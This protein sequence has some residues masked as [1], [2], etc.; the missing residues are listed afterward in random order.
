[1]TGQ[2]ALVAHRRRPRGTRKILAA[3][4]VATCWTRTEAYRLPY[5]RRGRVTSLWQSVHRQGRYH[6]RRDQQKPQN[7]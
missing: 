6:E 1:M 3:V 7:F 4:R 5:K 2:A